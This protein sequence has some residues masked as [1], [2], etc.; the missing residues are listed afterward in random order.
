MNHLR[1]GE[2]ISLISQAKAAAHSPDSFT[3]TAQ[4]V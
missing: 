1:A 2:Q 4:N 3:I